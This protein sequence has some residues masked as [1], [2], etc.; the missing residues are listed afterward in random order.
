MRS[1]CTALWS[2]L[3]FIFLTTLPSPAAAAAPIIEP[4]IG[5]RYEPNYDLGKYLASAPFGLHEYERLEDDSGAARIVVGAEIYPGDRDFEKTSIFLSTGIL[6]GSTFGKGRYDYPTE[7]FD[8]KYLEATRTSREFGG[9]LGCGLSR[10]IFKAAFT[11]YYIDLDSRVS[12]LNINYVGDYDERGWSTSVE[13]KTVTRHLFAPSVTLTAFRFL[14][15]RLEGWY[16]LDYFKYD[17]A[18]SY[19]SSEFINPTQPTPYLEDYSSD[20]FSFAV[21]LTLNLGQLWLLKSP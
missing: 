3:V 11:Y 2:A 20:D 4:F 1:I 7:D 17:A 15:L 12:I 5:I 9:F 21:Q 8:Q 16:E 10:G 18:G 13:T 14:D 19:S 6:F